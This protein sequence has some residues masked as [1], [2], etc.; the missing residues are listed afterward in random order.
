MSLS[1]TPSFLVRASASYCFSHVTDAAV[2]TGEK[3]SFR[4][5]SFARDSQTPLHELHTLKYIGAAPHF[6]L[7]RIKAAR[8]HRCLGTCSIEA[9]V[10][11]L[12]VA[13]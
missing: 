3:S 8:L 7:L 1:I 9:L 2:R 4:Y 6:H 10:L 13:W 11:E 12:A 5:H